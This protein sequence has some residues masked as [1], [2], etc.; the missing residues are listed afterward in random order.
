MAEERDRLS[1]YCPTDVEMVVGIELE[2]AEK[3]CRNPNPVAVLLAGQPGAGKT[4]LS[5]ML[6]KA[7]RNDVYFINGDEYRRFHPNYKR[8][9][10]KYGSDAV[11]LTGKFSGEVTERLIQET[12]E[13][14]INLIIEGTGKTT[15]VPHKTAAL[16][17]EKGYRVELAVIATRP[18]QSLCSTLLRFYEM[19]EGGTIPR[20]T[21]ASAHDHIVDVLPDN[22]D[23]LC[24]DPVISKIAIWDRVPE[25]VYDSGTDF[26]P[27]SEALRQYWNRPWLEDEYQS[28]IQTI[29][30]LREKEEKYHLGQTP[31]ID[32]L[33]RRM[34]NITCDFQH[35][36]GNMTML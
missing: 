33:E 22:L 19:N 29:D 24:G 7:M 20:A 3:Y 16:L 4:V 9:F 13:R 25:K 36:F 21:A 1:D 31:A 18:E 32:E 12:S 23:V 30:V 34:Q 11:Q 26:G 28:M 15:E 10:E 6:N 35:T 5:A 14:K 17:V 27:P 8:L 2:H